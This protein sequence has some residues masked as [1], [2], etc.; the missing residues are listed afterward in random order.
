M[1]LQIRILPPQNMFFTH[2]TFDSGSRWNWQ[3][4]DDQGRS[5]CKDISRMYSS[6]VLYSYAVFLLW[7]RNSSN[8]GGGLRTNKLFVESDLVFFLPMF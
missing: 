7:N 6:H 3:D 8:G 5:S 4:R 2:L 1:S